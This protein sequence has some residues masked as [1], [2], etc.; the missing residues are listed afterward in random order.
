MKSSLDV[1]QT[2]DIEKAGILNN[3]EKQLYNHINIINK[4]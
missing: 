3:R 4:K 2:D 1:V